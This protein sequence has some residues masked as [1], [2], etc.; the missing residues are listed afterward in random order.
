MGVGSHKN[1]T[2]PT[3]NPSDVTSNG[4]VPVGAG[5]A[6]HDR[7]LQ[8][9]VTLQ[10]L[11]RHVV[12]MATDLEIDA[13]LLE[14]QVAQHDM[15]EEGGQARIVQ[16]DLVGHGIELQPERGLDQ[17]ERRGARPGL[18]RAGN[19][20][21]RRPAAAAPPE[22][23]EQLRQPLHLHV[24]RG[25]EQACEQALDRALQAVAREPE[26]DQRIVVRPDRTVVV[27]HRI[28]ARFSVRDRADAPAG[29]E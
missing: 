7:H 27:G 6:V 25:I 8:L 18:R 19:R 14:L 20:I 11:H 28:V 2:Q 24:G 15:V 23:A 9:A 1:S 17:R 16:A 5:G 21:E 22:A 26:R 29:E 12:G 10:D 3:L 4:V 13:R